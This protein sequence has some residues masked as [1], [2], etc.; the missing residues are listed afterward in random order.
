MWC[1]RI[2]INDNFPSLPIILA[3]KGVIVFLFFTFKSFRYV[4]NVFH[5]KSGES[6]YSAQL[7]VQILFWNRLN[8]ESVGRVNTSTFP[9]KNPLTRQTRRTFTLSRANL[10]GPIRNT[11]IVFC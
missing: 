2:T 11:F 7:V 10:N 6:S 1:N 4:A 3:G 8:Q 5:M 9:G